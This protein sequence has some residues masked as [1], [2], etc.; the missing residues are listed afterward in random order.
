MNKDLEQFKGK[1]IA[2]V[3][4]GT[5]NKMKDML[6]DSRTDKK[7]EEFRNMIENINAQHRKKWN[8]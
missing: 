3:T 6:R 2:Q 7:V 8:T 5:E 4:T 1:I